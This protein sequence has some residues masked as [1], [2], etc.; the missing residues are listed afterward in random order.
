MGM[1]VDSD[2]SF[3]LNTV[4]TKVN[5]KVVY[6]TVSEALSINTQT[7]MKESFSKKTTQF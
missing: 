7:T 6:Q 2:V 3:L 5:S 1:Q 4:F